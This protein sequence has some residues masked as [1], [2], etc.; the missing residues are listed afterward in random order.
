MERAENQISSNHLRQDDLKSNK[1]SLRKNFFSSSKVI[2]FRDY[3]LLEISYKSF[4]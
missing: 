1:N 4:V 3:E 2:L